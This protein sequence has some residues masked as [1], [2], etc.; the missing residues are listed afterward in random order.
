MIAPCHAILRICAV[1]LTWMHWQG[2]SA[3]LA[4]LFCLGV[5]LLVYAVFAF[6]NGL[7]AREFPTKIPSGMPHKPRPRILGM[8]SFAQHNS[9]A[10]D[11][12]LLLLNAD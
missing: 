2:S 6:L 1:Q 11:V 10:Y 8:V 4:L 5:G 3:G 7:H 12:C 9:P